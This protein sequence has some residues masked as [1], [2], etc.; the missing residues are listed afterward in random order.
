MASL[1]CGGRVKLGLT[2]YRDQPDISAASRK[3][4][5]TAVSVAYLLA[6]PV[7]RRAAWRRAAG[8]ISPVIGGHGDFSWRR[9]L[10]AAPSTRRRHR[11]AAGIDGQETPTLRRLRRAL[12][13][14]RPART[15]MREPTDAR[16]SG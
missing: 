16:S 7:L 5:L 10:I 4:A 3:R 2:S 1:L 15:S 12:L 9:K 13:G 8:A 6:A 11:Q 14:D